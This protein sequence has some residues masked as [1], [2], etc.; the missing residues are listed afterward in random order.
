MSEWSLSR[1]QKTID[2]FNNPFKFWLFKWRLLPA[3]GFIGLKMTSLEAKK[4]TVSIKYGWR[5]RNPYQS[6]YF[7]A[8]CAAGELATG[9][10]ATVISKGF[11]ENILMLV[12]SVEA[13]FTKKAVG[14]IAFTCN[15]GESM[16]GVIQNA[17]VSDAA[18]IFRATAIGT[19]EKGDIVSKIYISWSFK[20][21]K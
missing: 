12:V 10:I 6:M 3:A 13:E 5:N 14:N 11:V 20:Y 15:E 21:K 9:A 7:A 19:D 2:Q 17:I 8:Q 1:S 16:L 4:C 18:R